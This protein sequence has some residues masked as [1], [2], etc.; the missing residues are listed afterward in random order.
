VLITLVIIGVIAALTIP[1]LMQKYRKHEVETKLLKFYS[2]MNNALA[3]S[4]RDNGRIEDWPLGGI[5]NYDENQVFVDTYIKNYIKYT[6]ME[7]ENSHLPTL[8]IKI[9][10]DDG[11]AMNIA[12]SLVVFYPNAKKTQ[13]NGK[14][15]FVFRINKAMQYKR[16]EK[17]VPHC[18]YD[19]STPQ[20]IENALK[21]S[22]YGCVK[23][24]NMWHCALLIQRNGWKIP[25]DYPVRF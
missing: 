5:Y 7:R 22:P 11:S 18:V 8:G 12:N 19:V 9:T 13:I 25:D 23:G 10:F 17:L 20:A 24:A 21:N 2:T 3:L 1:N 14:D 4:E 15:A 16:K 6:K